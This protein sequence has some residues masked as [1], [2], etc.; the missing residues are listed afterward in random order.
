VL[1]EVVCGTLKVVGQRSP[2]GE[3][4]LDL[5]LEKPIAR[6]SAFRRL[7]WKARHVQALNEDGLSSVGA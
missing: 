5:L 4:Q 2:H 7:S 6:P 1:R 3:A